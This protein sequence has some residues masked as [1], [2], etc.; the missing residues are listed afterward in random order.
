MRLE[1]FSTIFSHLCPIFPVWRFSLR[2]KTGRFHLVMKTALLLSVVTIHACGSIFRI[3]CRRWCCESC[4]HDGEHNKRQKWCYDF[5]MTDDMKEYEWEAN[6]AWYVLT[7]DGLWPYIYIYC[8]PDTC[9][10]HLSQYNIDNHVLSEARHQDKL[11]AGNQHATKTYVYVRT[12]MPL[13]SYI[14]NMFL[15]TP[16]M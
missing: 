15:S 6:D 7:S 5:A 4:H 11:L 1:T 16:R 9:V 8:C 13:H 12:C 2:D 10:D 14:R 3:F